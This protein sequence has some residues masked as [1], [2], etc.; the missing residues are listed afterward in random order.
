M[1]RRTVAI[2]YVNSVGTCRRVGYRSTLRAARAFVLKTF[3]TL[4]TFQ[5]VRE[6]LLP[7]AGTG[8]ERS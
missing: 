8:P 5:F 3:G 4:S 1:R 2:Y 7:G 6:G